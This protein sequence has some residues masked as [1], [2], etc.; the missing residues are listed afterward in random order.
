ML[1]Y[2]YVDNSNVFIEAQRVSAVEEGMAADLNDAIDRRVFNF[3]YKLDYGKLYE[4][5]CGED[6]RQV[7][8]AK[9]WG[10]PPPSDS[11]W[12]MVESKGFEVVTYDRNAAG[13]EKKVDVAI[14]HAITKD[15]YTK[16]NKDD[17]EIVLVA[18]DKDYV[19]VIEDLKSEGYRVVVVFWDHAAYELKQAANKFISL[20]QWL[21]YLQK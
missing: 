12:A 15:A 8:C 14:A 1:S 20:N 3:N 9:L 5:L 4:Y 13:K 16:V 19:P 7:G 2:T 11:F 6:D 21:S 18:G 10:S 17:S